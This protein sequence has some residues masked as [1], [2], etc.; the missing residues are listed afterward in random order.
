MNG[1]KGSALGVSRTARETTRPSILVIEVQTCIARFLTMELD[2]FH[3]ILTL[4]SD[5]LGS[6]RSR[7]LDLVLLDT[8]VT[9]ELRSRILAEANPARVQVVMIGEPPLQP[10]EGHPVSSTPA[11]PGDLFAL[12]RRYIPEG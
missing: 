9:T 5:A 11:S 1:T 4:P 7:H 10:A 12:L 8:A 6:L 2:D 3:L